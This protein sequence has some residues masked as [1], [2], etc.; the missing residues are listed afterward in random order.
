MR[1]ATLVS[2]SL[3]A[4]PALAEPPRVATDIPPVTSLV[5]QVMGDLGT[6]E[7]IVPVGASPHHVAL[8][9]SEAA[10][11]E[12]AS[13]VIW[14]GPELS[15]GLGDS[16]SALA[17][18]TPTL[19]LFEAPGTHHLPARDSALFADHG[20]DDHGHGHG[21]DDHDDEEHSGDDPHL[22]LDPENAIAWLDAI[23]SALSEADPENA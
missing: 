22:W 23:A 4:A 12:A 19:E 21:H 13:L 6:P 3:L 20:H 2:L 1:A 15:P 7:Q 5:A 18:D 16:I 11:L 9:P 17:A 8:R 14:I 10:A